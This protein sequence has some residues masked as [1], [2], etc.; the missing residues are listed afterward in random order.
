MA[1]KSGKALTIKGSKKLTQYNISG[2]YFLIKDNIVVYVGKS[3]N[4]HG[5]MRKHVIAGNKDFDEVRYIEADKS[6]IL[7]KEKYYT[8][9][10]RPKYNIRN[11]RSGIVSIKC[12]ENDFD[13]EAEL[14]AVLTSLWDAIGSK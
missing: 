1:D 10:Y 5:R 11:R 8:S 13:A 14:D 3:V 2:I 7:D 4:I 9:L 12:T 6:V